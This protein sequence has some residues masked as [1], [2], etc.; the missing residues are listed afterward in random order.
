MAKNYGGQ[1]L[2]LAAWLTVAKYISLLLNSIVPTF[3][4]D[5]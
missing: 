5:Y 2:S 3:Q 1:K 4:Q